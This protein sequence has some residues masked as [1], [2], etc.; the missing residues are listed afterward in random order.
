MKACCTAESKQRK[1]PWIDT[2]SHR[3]QT[4]TFSH[5]CV[6]DPKDP[7]RRSNSLD[8]QF[9]GQNVQHRIRRLSVQRTPAATKPIGIQKTQRHIGVSDGRFNAAIAVTR[10]T[11]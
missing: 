8:P 9:S 2:A 11:G 5:L 1:A 7:F 6:D 3:R 10:R 4:H